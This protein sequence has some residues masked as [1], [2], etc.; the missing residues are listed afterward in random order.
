MA[1]FAVFRRF[2]QNRTFSLAAQNHA[3]IYQKVKSKG[4]FENY[5][6]RAFHIWSHILAT[7]LFS[8]V[9]FHLK[10]VYFCLFLPFFAVFGNL[11][12]FLWQPK[13]M[14][15]HIRKLKV[16]VVLKRRDQGLSIYGLIYPNIMFY[17]LSH[18]CSIQKKDQ[19]ICP[20]PWTHEELILGCLKTIMRN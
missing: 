5:R 9:E 20:V 6:S 2:R 16:M 19:F 12:N 7:M 4:I 3:W 1:I 18:I 15:T 8:W 11:I 13:T 10:I 14:H 17:F